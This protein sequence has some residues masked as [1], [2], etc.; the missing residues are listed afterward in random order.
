MRHRQKGTQSIIAK[1][2]VKA[3]CARA[4]KRRRVAGHSNISGQKNGD[5][6]GAAE[7]GRLLGWQHVEAL[8]VSSVRRC[9]ACARG[10]DLRQLL[11]TIGRLHAMLNQELEDAD[12]GEVAAS[13]FGGADLHGD[14]TAC[15]E[16]AKKQKPQ[17]RAMDIPD[18]PPDISFVQLPHTAEAIGFAFEAKRAAMGPHIMRRWAWD[19]EFQ[20]DLHQRRFDEKPFYQIRRCQTPIGT[21][22]FHVEADHVRFGEFYLFPIFQGQGLGRP[23][24]PAMTSSGQPGASASTM[25]PAA[26]DAVPSTNCRS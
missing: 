17:A 3:T 5:A 8:P 20:R 24:R 22:S 2:S 10:L 14:M 12:G 6:G 4:L 21:L 15:V 19:E 26:A 9:R 7:V 23:W 18:L 13:P 11:Q 25:T 1:R 16:L